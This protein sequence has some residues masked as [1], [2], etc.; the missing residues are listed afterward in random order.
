MEQYKKISDTD[1]RLMKI[2]SVEEVVR[3]LRELCMIS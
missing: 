1:S 3:R 2:L